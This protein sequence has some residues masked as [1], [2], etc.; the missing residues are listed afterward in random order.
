LIPPFADLHTQTFI[1][2][3]WDHF[4]GDM[5]FF[6]FSNCHVQVDIITGRF[7]PAIYGSPRSET[8]VS[9]RPCETGFPDQGR[10]CKLAEDTCTAMQELLHRLTLQFSQA[11]LT[12]TLSII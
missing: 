11:R 4:F 7:D 6:L 5:L 12:S 10:P 3:G 8:P 1:V 2:S 9:D